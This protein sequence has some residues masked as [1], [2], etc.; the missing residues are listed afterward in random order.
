MIA[1][2]VSVNWT[3]SELGHWE[4]YVKFAAGVHGVRCTVFDM[5]FDPAELYAV[6]VTV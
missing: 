1:D 5:V 6:R 4:R 3:L 2:V